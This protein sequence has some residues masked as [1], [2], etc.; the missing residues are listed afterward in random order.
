MEDVETLEH[1]VSRPAVRQHITAPVTNME[2]RTGRIRKHI[3]TVVFRSRIV[4]VGFVK[5]LCGPVVPPPGFDVG[6]VVSAVK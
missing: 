2:T 4:V 3:Q 6:V 5:M 1:F